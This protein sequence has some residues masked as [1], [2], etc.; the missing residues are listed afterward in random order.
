MT[1]REIIAWLLDSDP[2]I[3]WQ[4]KRDLLG[5]EDETFAQERMR[6]STEGWGADLLSRQDTSGR[7]AGQLYDHKWISTTYTM[8]LLRRMGLDP[9]N[10]Q[11]HIACQQLLEGGY[12]KDGALSFA[13][14]VSH[15]DLGVSGL[16]L[17]ILAYFGYPDQRVHTVLEFLLDQ[18]L[19]DGSW[20]PE[21]GLERLQYIFAG[22]M[23]VLDGLREYE[24]RYSASSAQ[25]VEAQL[26]GREFLS[27]H[28]LFKSKESKEILDQKLTRFSFPPRWH[29]DV[30]VALDYFQDCSTEK[31]G[32]LTDAIELVK[33]RCRKD[34]R[35]NLQNRHPGKTY[36]EME[37]VGQPSRWNTLRALRV[38]K[39][40]GEG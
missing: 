29:Y 16:V 3:R 33:S 24:K 35:W 26:K 11:A 37:E 31:D 19:P 13:K 32:R 4:V 12:K 40:W 18:Q 1:E 6:V 8:Q 30:L 23:L 27:G 21:P 39:W 36:F 5:E 9:G 25:V 20:V 22:T 28:Y 7:W 38:L 10:P 15:I 14:T 34:G 17:S 2:S